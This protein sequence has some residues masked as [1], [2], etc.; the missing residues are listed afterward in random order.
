MQ[1]AWHLLSADGLVT[2]GYLLAAG[3]GAVEPSADVLVVTAIRF[4]LYAVAWVL[5]V[6]LPTGQYL[7]AP[8]WIL[9]A[10]I[11]GLAWASVAV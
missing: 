1:A 11:A 8:Q 3:L 2:A 5:L 10:L 4:A 7:R 6:C 9:L